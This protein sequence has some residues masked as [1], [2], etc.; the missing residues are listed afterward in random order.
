[1][2][3][4][5][6]VIG[7]DLVQ[8]PDYPGEFIRGDVRQIDA[9]RL[10]QIDADGASLI[11]ASPPC[12]DFSDLKRLFG[13]RTEPNLELVSSTIR[14]ARE[15]GIPLVLEN[16]RGLQDHFQPAVGHYGPFYLWGDILPAQI[17]KFPGRSHKMRG[18][19]PS[20]RSIIPFELAFAVGR[21]LWPADRMSPGQI[22]TRRQLVIRIGDSPVGA[23]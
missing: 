19:D 7:L 1:M 15:S 21:A 3:A 22:E 5:W 8:Y 14:L 16:V 10:R 13:Q 9:G 23:N 6:R 20:E 12:R 4:G 2:A 18:K 17:P 11:V